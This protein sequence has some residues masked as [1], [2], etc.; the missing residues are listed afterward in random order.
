[1]DYSDSESSDDETPSTSEPKQTGGAL[2]LS[3]ADFFVISEAADVYVKKFKIHGKAYL[4]QLRNQDQIEDLQ[5]LLLEI[6]RQVISQTTSL[7]FG[8]MDVWIN[9]VLGLWMISAS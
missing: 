3:P 5:V 9:P 6:L 1:M 4:V 7:H 8:F 2:Q